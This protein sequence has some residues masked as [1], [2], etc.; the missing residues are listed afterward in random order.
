MTEHLMSA[1]QAWQAH[2]AS[3][4]ELA[5]VAATELAEEARH[6]A[7]VAEARARSEHTAAT[8]AATHDE[9]T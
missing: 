4:R 2:D 6:A 7:M 9:G 5:D 1:V 3:I 8:V